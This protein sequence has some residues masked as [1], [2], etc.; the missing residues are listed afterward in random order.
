MF[1]VCIII[2]PE[3]ATAPQNIFPIPSIVNNILRAHMR[4]YPYVCQGWVKDME[5]GCAQI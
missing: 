2:Y 4:M 5:N 3:H 1:N